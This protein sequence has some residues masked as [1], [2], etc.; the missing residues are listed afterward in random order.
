VHCQHLAMQCMETHLMQI[1]VLSVALWSAVVITECIHP[2]NL[3]Q[4]SA[5]PPWRVGCQGAVGTPL[6]RRV[7]N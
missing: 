1:T 7:R 4:Q 2:Q 3:K 6:A 5:S